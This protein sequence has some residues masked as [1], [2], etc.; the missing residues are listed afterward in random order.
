MEMSFTKKKNIAGTFLHELLIARS[1]T[2]TAPFNKVKIY[3]IV[4]FLWF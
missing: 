2:F 1:L 3:E 4:S